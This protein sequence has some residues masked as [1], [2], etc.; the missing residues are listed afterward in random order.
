GRGYV[1]EENNGSMRHEAWDALTLGPDGA[2]LQE[3]LT[4]HDV[5]GEPWIE[6]RRTLRVHE[7]ES[8]DELLLTVTTELAALPGRGPFRFTSPMIE[9]RPDPSGYSGLALRLARAMTG[10]RIVNAAGTSGPEAMGQRAA[11]LHY[12]AKLDGSAKLCG[13]AVF[14]HPDNPRHPSPFFVRATPFGMINPAFCWD[15]PYELREGAPL[16]L[17]YGVWVHAGE[18]GPERVADVYARWVGR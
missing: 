6:E 7:P 9:G 14:D 13:A 2:L 4:W 10:G 17:T 8:D 1:Q 16:R 12:A 3:R 18:A 11:W 5:R 15:E